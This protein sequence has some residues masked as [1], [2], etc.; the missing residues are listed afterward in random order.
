MKQPGEMLRCTLSSTAAALVE[1]GAAH[2]SSDLL[3]ALEKES[4]G[5]HL[6]ALF[7]L[8]NRVPPATRNMLAKAVTC[9][10]SASVKEALDHET[11]AELIDFT[12]RLRSGD[13]A[14]VQHALKLPQVDRESAEYIA[15]FSPAPVLI[16][17]SKVSGLTDRFPSFLEFLAANP[18]SDLN[19]LKAYGLA[20][21][22]DE[23]VEEAVAEDASKYKQAMK[24]KI[25]IKIKTA[26]SGDKE[27]RGIFL[28]DSNRL[29]KNAVIKNPRITNAEIVA[30]CNDRTATEEM[31]RMILMKKDWAKLPAVQ[32]ALVVHP[33]TPLPR[34]L[35]FMSILSS[36]ELKMLAKSKSVAQT[37]AVTAKR[38]LSSDKK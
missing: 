12:I 13:T 27:W 24:M 37:I 23:D 15:R 29:V 32:R 2:L 30:I 34:A 14:A 6:V 5:D 22:S 21:E 28:K 7:A 20:D 8:Y 9:M 10:A 11:P 38:M 36:K 17:C 18:A 16:A 26:L 4:S 31:I 3:S 19:V 35:R 1:T 25:S 33:R